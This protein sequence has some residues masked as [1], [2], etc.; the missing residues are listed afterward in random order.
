TFLGWLDQ[1]LPGS[2]HRPVRERAIALVGHD[3]HLSAWRAL[4]R[5]RLQQAMAALQAAGVAP[6]RMRARPG[7]P[8]EVA[9]YQGAPGYRFVYDLT[10]EE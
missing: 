8:Q 2:A 1:Q 5:S 9:A 4:E 7:T 6:E 10:E 3:A